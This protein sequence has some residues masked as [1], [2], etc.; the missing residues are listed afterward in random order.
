MFQ[1]IEKNG[2]FS[3][4]PPPPL[5]AEFKTLEKQTQEGKTN[6]SRDQYFKHSKKNLNP[7]SMFQ[8]HPL[9]IQMVSVYKSESQK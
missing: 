8:E 2:D 3:P 7:S 1:F 6:K 4:Y 5:D 9:N